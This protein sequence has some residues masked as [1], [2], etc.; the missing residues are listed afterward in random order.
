MALLARRYTD[1]LRECSDGTGE[2]GM[3]SYGTRESALSVRSE[4]QHTHT[5]QIHPHQYHCARLEVA[6]SVLR[7]RS[8][9]PQV[10]RSQRAGRVRGAF[11]PFLFVPLPN[12]PGLAS[13]ILG[14][15]LKELA[16][17]GDDDEWR[18]ALDAS[19]P[20]PRVHARDM[21]A[22]GRAQARGCAADP[23]FSCEPA[24]CAPRDAIRGPRRLR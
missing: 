10:P 5:L 14:E 1:A 20:P 6:A 2:T 19:G 11:L 23:C 13:Q 8:R 4:A 3:S 21:R 15:L 18:E 17:K 22:V 24:R 12:A 16:G 9:L 7:S